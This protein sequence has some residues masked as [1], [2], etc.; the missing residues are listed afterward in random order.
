MLCHPMRDPKKENVQ[1]LC[2]KYNSNRS[3]NYIYVTQQW[4][5]TLANKNCDN[6]NGMA[7]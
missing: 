6:T 2:R 4:E 5:N 3:K 7:G 1:Q